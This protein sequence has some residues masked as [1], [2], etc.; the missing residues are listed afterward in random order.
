MDL[1]RYP[2]LVLRYRATNVAK[3]AAYNIWLD[4]GSGSFGHGLIPLF[5]DQLLTDGKVHEVRRD[6]RLLNP[7][8]PITAMA[9]KLISE[10]DTPATYDLIGLHFEAAPKTEPVEAPSEQ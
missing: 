6:L 8:G 4:D 2:F 3:T 9:L 1:N 7:A 10:Q 5:L